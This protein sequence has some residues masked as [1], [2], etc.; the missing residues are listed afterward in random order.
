[1]G[2]NNKVMCSGGLQRRKLCNV[3]IMAD[4]RTPC[5]GNFIASILEL[6]ETMRHLGS[7]VCFLFPES[8]NGG[9]YS[10]SRWLEDC[11]FSVTLLSD[12]TP[13]DQ[14]LSVLEELV[15]AHN[16]QIIHT[17]F[18]LYVRLLLQNASKLGVKAL[19]H[20][21]M[22]FSPEGNL[23]KQK[24]RS[25]LSS[26][27]YRFRGV[28]VVSVMELKS[29]YYALCGKRY[30]HYVPNGLSL[31]RNAPADVSRE[32]RRREW[33]IPDQD[34]V[35]LFLGWDKYRKGMD[36]AVKA[37]AEVRKTDPTLHL[38]IIGVGSPP[39]QSTVDWIL[40]KTGVDTSCGWLHFL[41]S[42]EDM[43]ACHRAADVYISAS[44]KEAFSY[45]LLEAISQNTPVV[46]S[47]IEGT[48]WAGAYTKAVMYPVEDVSACA[49]AIRSALPMGGEPSNYDEITERYSIDLWCKRIMDIYASMVE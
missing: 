17:H 36:I 27:V 39:W 1:M 19:I 18:G 28:H 45:G 40:D 9:G 34:K 47:D 48:Q 29:K 43:F 3:L 31:R 30:C 33:G 49:E 35:C 22:D 46:V 2:D 20:D 38:G 25:I 15:R 16:I 24:L 14:V 8:R 23:L 41:P 6:A 26:C 5:S 42:Y 4:Y 11:G 44:R 37:V 10:W 32:A 21:H 13:A 12:Q 7:E